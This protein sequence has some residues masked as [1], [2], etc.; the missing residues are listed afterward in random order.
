FSDLVTAQRGAY[1]ALLRLGRFSICSASPE[2]FFARTG[3]SILARPMKGT[4][5]RG[6]TLLE[7]VKQREEVRAS[8][9]QQAENVMVVDMVRNDLGR[10]AAIG[11]VRVPELF[12]VERYPNVWQM[13]STVEGTSSASLSDIFQALHPSAS[14]TGAPKASTMEIVS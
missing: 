2:L 9:K 3:D 7:D 4:A 5:R 6:R 8:P 10:I 13:T 1:A 14:V 11:S 12:N